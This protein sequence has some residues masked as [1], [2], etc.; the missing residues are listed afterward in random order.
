MLRLYRWLRFARSHYRLGDR[1]LAQG[2][3]PAR[4][5]QAEGAQNDG[6]TPPR[7]RLG[8]VVG[9]RLGPSRPRGARQEDA[10]SMWLHQ[11]SHLINQANQLGPEL[12]RSIRWF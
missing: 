4:Q 9:P 8:A 10:A 12:T 3:P 1:S 7:P 2:A 11:P 6:S 5:P